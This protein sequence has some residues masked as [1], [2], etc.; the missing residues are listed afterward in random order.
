MRIFIGSLG[1]IYRRELQS[2][3]V[4]PLAYAIAG[5][6]W[7]LTGLLFW[8]ILFGPTGAIAQAAQIDACGAQCREQYAQ[9]GL[10]VPNSIDVPYEFLQI[11]LQVIL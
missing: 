7:L 3:F 2:Y 1:A 5:V 6:F 11:F 8:L 4:S 10:S 9:M